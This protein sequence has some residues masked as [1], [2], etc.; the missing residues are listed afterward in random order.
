[1]TRVTRVVDKVDEK[2]SDTQTA[3]TR[4]MAHQLDVPDRLV[5]GESARQGHG[6][7]IMRNEMVVVTVANRRLL[8]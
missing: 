2:Y 4:V 8:K 5:L 7:V 1:M 3:D 6:S